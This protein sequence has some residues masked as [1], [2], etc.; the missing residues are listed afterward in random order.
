MEELRDKLIKNIEVNGRESEETISIS[1][2]LDLE[3]IKEMRLKSDEE[4]KEIEKET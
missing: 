4:S 3:I 1:Q 2:E